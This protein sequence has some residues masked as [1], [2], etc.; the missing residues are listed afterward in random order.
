MVLGSIY[1]IECSTC[2]W[3]YVGETGRTIEERKK[4]HLQAVRQMDVQRSDV[5]RHA[6]EDGHDVDVKGMHLIEKEKNWKKRVIKEALWTKKL[7]SNNKVK[8]DL[9][10][11]WT[12]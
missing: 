4:E 2:A 1:N 5:A 9:G 10:Q 6:I 8:H 12:L 7:R 11:V 3:N